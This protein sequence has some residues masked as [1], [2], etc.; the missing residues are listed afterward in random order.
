MSDAHPIEVRAGEDSSGITIQLARSAFG[1]VHGHDRGF[2]GA[3]FGA[4][5]VWL[6]SLRT[7][8]VQ[9]NS[10]GFVRR[11]TLPGGSRSRTSRRATKLEAF[12]VAW[13]ERFAREGE[14][15]AGPPPELASVRVTVADGRTETLSVCT[16]TGFRVRGQVF[17][18]GAP[19]TGESA[20]GIRVS[21]AAPLSANL[22]GMSVPISMPLSPDGTFALTGVQGP[23]LLRTSAA[24][25]GAF[26]HHTSITGMDVSER[27]VEVT[28]DITAVEIT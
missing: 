3:P 8:G 17:V 5:N 6:V 28:A 4:A 2:E 18:D 16:S 25:A 27:G 26:F 9:V 13:M 15:R 7:V 20:A 11:L 1:A 23:R 19:L 14:L 22:S 10:A 12:S 24:P 21:A